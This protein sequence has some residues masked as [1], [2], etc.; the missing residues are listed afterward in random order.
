MGT[1]DRHALR[2]VER[3]GVA[4]ID[5]G[6]VL[7]VE[8]DARATVEPN[9]HA[10]GRHLLDRAKRAVL[11]PQRPLV[12]QEH[13]AVAARERARPPVGAE[14]HVIAKVA[15]RAK[16][17]TRL[18]VQLANLG[19]GVGEDNAGF[20]RLG[21]ARTIPA[22]D[23]LAPRLLARVGR[24]DHALAVISVDRLAGAPRRQRARRALLPVLALPPDLGD[25][26]R[27]VALGDAAERRARLDRLQLLGVAHHDDLGP[28]IAGMGEHPLHLT[29]ADHARLVHDQHVARA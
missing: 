17:A 27:A 2:F 18:L 16:P 14:R 4:V 24:V 5:M 26:G 6:I 21:L 19:V 23:Q 15:G 1:I 11:H 13:Q 7:R 22:V 28:C 25:L 12:P 20:A 8:R 9:L 10:L 29:R 3:G